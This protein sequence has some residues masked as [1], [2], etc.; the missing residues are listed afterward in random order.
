VFSDK[1]ERKKWIYG[2][3]TEMNNPIP[4]DKTER[5]ERSFEHAEILKGLLL[6]YTEIHKSE[7]Y[8]KKPCFLQHHG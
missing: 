2:D 7:V 8:P 4:P 6:E 3:K 5:K 1:T